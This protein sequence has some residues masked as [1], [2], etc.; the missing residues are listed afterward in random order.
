MAYSNPFKFYNKLN[1]VKYG[2]PY[3]T[4]DCQRFNKKNLDIEV[5]FSKKP[6]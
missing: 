2:M 3:I 4:I 6:R 1:M 5:I